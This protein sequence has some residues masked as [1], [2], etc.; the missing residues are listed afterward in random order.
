MVL[1]CSTAA[2]SLGKFHPSVFHETIIASELQEWLKERGITEA[3]LSRYGK[4]PI[5]VRQPQDHLKIST[6]PTVTLWHKD[7]LG[8]E[9]TSLTRI[10]S[11]KWLLMWS[12]GTAT[13]IR[14][15][16]GEITFQPYD[17]LLAD[18]HRVQ[19]RCPPPEEGRWFVRL[20]DPIGYLIGRYVVV[21]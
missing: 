12:N 13:N 19:H 1:E 11:L 8:K 7:G 9:A 2:V 21:I 18:N 5:E 17:V 16:N 10:P 4:L 14:D 3:R 20:A 15:E 6:D